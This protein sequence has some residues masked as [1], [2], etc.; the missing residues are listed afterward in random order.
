MEIMSKN[1]PMAIHMTHLELS[2]G[3]AGSGAC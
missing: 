3:L 1:N 2:G